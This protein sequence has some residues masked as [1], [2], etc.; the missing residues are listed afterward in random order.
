M[1]RGIAA[2]AALLC[3]LLAACSGQNAPVES[4]LP[5]GQSSEQKKVPYNEDDVKT[6]LNAGIF[7]EEPE[8]LDL[9]IACGLIGVDEGLVESCRFYL[10]TSTNAEALALFVLKDAGDAESV[11]AACEDWTQDQIESYSSYGPEHVPKLEGA[12]LC[13]RENTVLLVVGADPAA[14]QSAVNALDG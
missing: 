1:R 10:P 7:S 13:V 2:A 8:Q 5:S 14:A 4:G 6:L 11:K 12:V 9:E 3:L